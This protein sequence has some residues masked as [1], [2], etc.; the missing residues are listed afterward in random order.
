MSKSRFGLRTLVLG[1]VGIAALGFAAF[2]AGTEL[3]FPSVRFAGLMV[4]SPIA[5]SA[6]LLV[7]STPLWGIPRAL[8]KRR[9]DRRENTKEENAGGVENPGRR[10]LFERS[11][12]RG[13]TAIP[14]VASLVGP[15]GAIAALSPPRL[16]KVTLHLPN[17]PSALDGFRILHL[18]DVH[19]GTF[20]DVNQIE[21]AL[22]LGRPHR[23]DLIALTGDIADDFE[24]LGPTL[25]LVEAEKAPAGSYACIGNHEIYRGRER[26]ESIHRASNTPLLKDEGKV[27][28]VNGAKLFVAGIDDPARLGQD[29]RSFLKSRVEKAV[30][31]CPDDVDFQL[32]LAH[33][34]EAFDSAAENGFDLTLSG[35]THGS[36]ISIW[37]R[38]LFELAAPRSYLLGHYQ[39]GDRHLHTSAGLG[40][41]FPLRLNC[42]CEVILVE[43]RQKSSSSTT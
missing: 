11:V 40:H 5:V 14:L 24:K 30:K 37:G 43:L 21:A 31:S 28:A 1:T 19:L 34:P 33:R 29:H 23:P 6:S 4:F 32:L 41:W 39:K 2:V 22:A 35:H 36:Q 16:K 9:V 26:C 15:L 18:T 42:P 27:L 7:V 13:T 3:G 10:L 38:S 20:I 25:A 12:D 17:L 8:L